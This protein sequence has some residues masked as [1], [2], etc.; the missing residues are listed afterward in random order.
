MGSKR[1]QEEPIGVPRSTVQVL[2]VRV[3]STDISGRV[4]LGEGLAK[5]DN[6]QQGGNPRST[7]YIIYLLIK[8]F[9][10]GFGVLGYCC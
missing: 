3:S 1:V 9:S 6:A 5:G 4:E 8:K 7:I 2:S 10:R